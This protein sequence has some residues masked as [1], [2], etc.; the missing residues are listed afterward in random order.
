[1][2]MEEFHNGTEIEQLTQILRLHWGSESSSVFEWLKAFAL[3]NGQRF[4][5]HLKTG[6][7][8]FWYSNNMFS[9]VYKLN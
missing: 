1:M 8:F 2:E 5:W 4:E 6:L 7:F 3:L 9:E